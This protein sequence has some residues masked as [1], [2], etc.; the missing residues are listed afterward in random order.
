LDECERQFGEKGKSFPLYAMLGAFSYLKWAFCARCGLAW[1]LLAVFMSDQFAVTQGENRMRR[2]P[3]L[4][5]LIILLVATSATGVNAS[6]DCQRWITAY[7]TELAHNRAVKKMQA[8]H[9]RV[10]RYAKRKM[11]NYIPKPAGPKLVRAH[12]VRPRYTRQQMLERFNLLCGDLPGTGKVADKM[13]QGT[14]TPVE[15]AADREAYVPE[16]LASLEVPET[17]GSVDGPGDAPTG[18]NPPGSSPF[19]GNQPPIVGGGGGGD[20]GDNPG[21]TGGTDGGTGGGTGGGST[22]PPVDPPA[23][24]PEPQSIV[25]VLTGVAGAAG[26][27]R[28]RLKS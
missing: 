20:K 22:P 23:P 15:F 28:R 5:L 16:E 12:A 8:A 18:T 13:L 9:A 3:I 7:K 21:G 4:L 14:M 19:F 11:A 1:G 26:A 27:I 2:K 10:R 17:I 6:T 24:V 25:L